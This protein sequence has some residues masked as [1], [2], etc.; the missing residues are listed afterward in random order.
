VCVLRCWYRNEHMGRLAAQKRRRLQTA[1]QLGVH[2]T[3][4]AGDVCRRCAVPGEMVRI[5]DSECSEL[6]RPGQVL[7]TLVPWR[8]VG[9][10]RA[11]AQLIG[12]WQAQHAEYFYKKRGL[13]GL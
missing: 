2:V 10:P 11:W 5:K 12:S 8:G 3:C 7:V 13:Q 9:W 1:L 6:W 4:C